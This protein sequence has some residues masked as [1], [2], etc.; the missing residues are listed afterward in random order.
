MEHSLERL[1]FV[2]GLP[3]HATIWQEPGPQQQEAAEREACSG[4]VAAVLNGS[5][6]AQSPD[7]TSKQT[8]IAASRFITVIIH[9]PY[10]VERS[11]GPAYR[12]ILSV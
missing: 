1:D 2:F 8:P 4:T 9:L 3:G 12:P 6:V 5:P 7:K 11:L 10:A